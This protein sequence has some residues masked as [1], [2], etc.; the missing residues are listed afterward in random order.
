MN[1]PWKKPLPR[2][3]HPIQLGSQVYARNSRGLHVPVETL[4]EHEQREAPYWVLHV[5]GAGELP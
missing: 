1:G 3:V 5:R 4:T 2:W